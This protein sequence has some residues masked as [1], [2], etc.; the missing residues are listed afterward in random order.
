MTTTEHKSLRGRPKTI[1]AEKVLEVAIEAYWQNDLADVSVNSICRA[2]QASKPSVYR[3]FGNEDGLTRA[4]LESY[5][6]Q[7]LSDVSKILQ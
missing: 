2:A 1:R 4:A 5:A 7:L 6:E 3:E